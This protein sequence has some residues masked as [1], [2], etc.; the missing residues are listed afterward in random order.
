MSEIKVD[1]RENTRD[2][3]QELKKKLTVSISMVLLAFVAIATAT[4]AWFSLAL[5]GVISDMTLQITTGDA[6][7]MNTVDSA[8]YDDYVSIITNA[9]INSQLS[10]HNLDDLRLAP[11]STM[12]GKTFKNYAAHTAGT[13]A[14]D[15]P[16]SSKMLLQLDV[17][18]WAKTE[19]GGSMDIKLTELNDSALT[20]G[21]VVTGSDS[22]LGNNT[23]LQQ[24]RID[25]CVRISFTDTVTGTTVIYEPN[26][27]KSGN[28]TWSGGPTTFGEGD[29]ASQTLFS[30]T[31]DTRKQI[32]IRVWIEGNDAECVNTTALNVSA[33]KLLMRLKFTAS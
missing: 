24:E 19:D 21:T 22:S 14:V 16:K 7:K 26:K 31:H 27:T 30:L 17:W 2:I 20:D 8:V 23:L 13:A 15:I 32:I 6:L 1:I 25:E 9:M 5:T 28:S 29:F 18:F 3:K 12:D 10:V 4:Y 33:A 11:L